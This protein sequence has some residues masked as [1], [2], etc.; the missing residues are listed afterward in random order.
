MSQVTPERRAWLKSL[1]VGDEVYTMGAHAYGVNCRPAKV[2]NITKSYIAVRPEGFRD[3]SA[4][5]LAS[6]V[7]KGFAYSP[8]PPRILP[9]EEGESLAKRY[10]LEKAKREARERADAEER[11]CRDEIGRRLRGFSLDQLRQVLEMVEGMWEEGE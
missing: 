1:K 5:S 3:T 7:L 8:N 4:Y 2:A 6:G 11:A 10:E 9:I